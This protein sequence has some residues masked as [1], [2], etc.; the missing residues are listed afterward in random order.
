MQ[1]KPN[2]GKGASHGNGVAGRRGK[3]LPDLAF[4]S[5][6]T[7]WVHAEGEGNH[8]LQLETS[9]GTSSRNAKMRGAECGDYRFF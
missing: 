7:K 5:G 4:S 9:A 1:R 2:T 3:F 6:Y 8:P